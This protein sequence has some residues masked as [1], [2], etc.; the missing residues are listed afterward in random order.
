MTSNQSIIL[1]RP[2]PSW[3][4][5]WDNPNVLQLAR[6][7]SGDAAGFI[8]SVIS[9]E[10]VNRYVYAYPTQALGD[11]S[12][13]HG[14]DRQKEI[15]ELILSALDQKDFSTNLTMQFKWLLRSCEY[16]R[17]LIKKFLFN[18]VPIANK[19]VT[20]IPKTDNEFEDL[21]QTSA[22]LVLSKSHNFIL[23][24]K[25]ATNGLCRI[26]AITQFT[27]PVSVIIEYTNGGIFEFGEVRK[28]MY[29]E[30][31]T[32][33]DPIEYIL[34]HFTEFNNYVCIRPVIIHHVDIDMEH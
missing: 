22:N 11:L 15:G 34:E 25:R 24:Y 3:I 16:Q 10:A 32:A 7:L 4:P 28:S 26:L 30:V 5:S 2:S 27:D 1:D 14:P 8:A 33:K 29:D 21:L 23:S 19:C 13:F 17:S 9:D 31:L 6:G 20:K 12:S 18:F